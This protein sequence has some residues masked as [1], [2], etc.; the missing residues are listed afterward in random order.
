MLD[1]NENAIGHSIE[2]SLNEKEGEGE[3]GLKP[4]MERRME[5]ATTKDGDGALVDR[6]EERLVRA[7]VV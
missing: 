2:V 7:C 5:R 4:T 1:A 6:V 3:K